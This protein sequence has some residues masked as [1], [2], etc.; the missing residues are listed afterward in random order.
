[1]KW[2]VGKIEQEDFC[3]KKALAQ[4]GNVVSKSQIPAN[5]KK[6]KKITWVSK[7]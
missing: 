7:F 3:N 2:S 6:K 5:V 4:H 1:M